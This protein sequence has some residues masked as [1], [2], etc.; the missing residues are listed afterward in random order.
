[1]VSLLLADKEK[2]EALRLKTQIKDIV[3]SLSDEYWKLECVGGNEEI[4]KYL[5]KTDLL[6]FACLDI[7]VDN[8][9]AITRQ[10][11][12]KYK[13]MAL[14][15]IANADISP[16]VYLRPG[17]R[18]DA[19]LIRPIDKKMAEDTLLEFLTNG[20]GKKEEDTADSFFLIKNKEERTFVPYNSICYFEARDKKIYACTRN[21]EYGFYASL[22]DLMETLPDQFMK[23]HR[24]FLVNS[25]MICRVLNAE[26]LL[27]LDGGIEVPLSRSFKPIFRD[28]KK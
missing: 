18:P 26:N 4:L 27:E 8:G 12:E 3:A 17:V 24:S 15:L 13:D 2:E 5:E 22:E 14:L 16:M 9:L 21:E 1:M 25:K 7:M 11:R 10:M 6:D 19:L 28:Y 20:L 23:C